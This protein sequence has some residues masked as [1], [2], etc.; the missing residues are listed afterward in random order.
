MA[1]NTKK[2]SCA[3]CDHCDEAARIQQRI[4]ER[5]VDEELQQERLANLWRRYR[6]VVIS[7][8]VLI[9]GG[10]VGYE[11]HR[12]WWQKTRLS[13]SDQYEAAVFNVYTG[14]AETAVAQLDE[15]AE[16]GKTGYRYLAQME[17]AGILLAMDKQD[18]ALM[19]LQDVMNDTDAPAPL[20]AA[21]TLGFVGHQIETGDPAEL[22]TLL[23]P[24]MNGGNPAFVASAAELSALLHVRAGDKAAAIR[25]AEQALSGD[26]V[27][28]PI[29]ERLTYLLAEVQK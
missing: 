18:E 21:A 2:K 26:K 17:A 22:Q 6:W 19:T 29:R 23:T 15:L 8:I 12:S 3:H 25:V 27:P 1:N 4:F 24:L 5:E 9:V 14:Q 28:L 11:A 16:S 13:E 10:A 7:G 20:R